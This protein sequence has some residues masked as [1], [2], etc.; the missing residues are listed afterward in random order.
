VLQKQFKQQ[1]SA[2]RMMIIDK[3]TSYGATKPVIMQGVEH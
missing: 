2:Q 3:L 1:G